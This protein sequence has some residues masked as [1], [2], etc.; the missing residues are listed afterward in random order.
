MKLIAVLLLSALP[1]LAAFP[2]DQASDNH[3]LSEEWFKNGEVIEMANALAQCAGLSEAL[4]V[5]AKAASKDAA[6]K[7]LH[8]NHNGGVVAALWLMAIDHN[9]RTGDQRALSE[10]SAYVDGIVETSKTRILAL[11]EIGGVESVQDEMQECA[12]L[13]ELQTVLVQQART[14]AFLN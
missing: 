2:Q 13:N 5:V 10:Y 9:I 14:S 3:Q 7:F 11:I 1:S 6:A 8:E 12:A 4:S